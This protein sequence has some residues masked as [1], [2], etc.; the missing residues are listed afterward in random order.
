V[1]NGF[2]L[3]VYYTDQPCQVPNCKD[4]A[5]VFG[6]TCKC[7]SHKNIGAVLK[8]ECFSLF[9][10]GDCTASCLYKSKN[11]RNTAQKRAEVTSTDHF[12]FFEARRC[13]FITSSSHSWNNK[14]T[15]AESEV[16]MLQV[17][18]MYHA[19]NPDTPFIVS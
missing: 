17:V 9:K 14:P 4:P 6:H 19:A 3:S 7:N 10:N 8:G 15:P 12:A 18:M 11:S 16:F 5:C 13:S 1:S 2:K